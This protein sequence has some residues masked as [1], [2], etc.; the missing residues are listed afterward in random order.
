M[1]S[2]SASE[3]YIRIT[4]SQQETMAHPAPYRRAWLRVEQTTDEAVVVM[5]WQNMTPQKL[6]ENVLW[7]S[8]VA[9]GL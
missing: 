5:N 3:I 6:Q 4:L 1:L 8:L 2:L 7:S 9:V